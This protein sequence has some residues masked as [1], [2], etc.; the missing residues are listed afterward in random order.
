MIKENNYKKCYKLFVD[1]L[2]S[3]NQKHP[4]ELYIL[5]GCSIDDKKREGVKI[6][7]NKIKFKYWGHTNVIF[8]SREIWRKEGDFSI[9]KNNK[10]KYNE[11]LDD[12]KLFLNESNF[13]MFFC[14]VDKK[15]T[16]KLGWGE[17]KTHKET[18][19]SIIKNFL[20]I[21]LSNDSRGEI[22]I[23][24]ATAEKD[25]FFHRSLGVFLSKGLTTP[26]TDFKKVQDTITS[27]SF[28]SKKNHD[29]EEQIADLLAYGAKCKYLKKK[30]KKGSYEDLILSVLKKTIY[31]KPRN[32]NKNKEKFLQEI[33]SFHTLP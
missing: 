28:V 7:T 29:I 33:N 19:N 3:T 13:K 1:E 23:E 15:K 5:S 24:S 14:I 30:I 22:V 16:S 12:L 2:G 6:F 21:S 32:T 20:L 31:K 8:H 17:A 18:T 26:K 11:F 4:S 27:I 25:F 10:K 9:F